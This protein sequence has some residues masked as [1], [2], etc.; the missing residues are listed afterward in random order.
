MSGQARRAQGLVQV[1]VAILCLSI[2]PILIKIGL[3]AGA[4]P[5][6]LL[7]ARL[8]LASVALWI[9]LLVFSPRACRIDRRG[10]GACAL[11]AAAN[12]CSLLTFYLA[13]A[14]ID[15]SVAHIIFALYP[16]AAL[17]LLAMRGERITRR[18]LVRLGL[19]LAG[20]YTL[21]G[22]GS[23]VDPLGAALVLVAAVAYGLHLTLVQWTLG[24]YAS[25][26]VTLY[27]LSFMALFLGAIRVLQC[28]PWVALTPVAWGVVVVTAIVSTV[29][30]RLLLFGGI[31]RIGSGQAALLGPVETLLTVTWAGLFLGERLLPLQWFGGLLVVA[32]V[33]LAAVPGPPDTRPLHPDAVAEH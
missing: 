26:T 1:L 33:L 8:V 2:T 14:R 19:G 11:V 28:A 6:T 13:L 9:V 12:S 16:V 20:V 23:G 10:L 31:R 4:D 21:V 29:V 3:T 17:L 32:S 15:A 27:V 5:V 18:R 7:L 24:G 22:L 25:E 30:A